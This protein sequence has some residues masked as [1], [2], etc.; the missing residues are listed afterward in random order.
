MFQVAILKLDLR[1]HRFSDFKK[2][3][4]N[5]VLWFLVYSLVDRFCLL[6]LT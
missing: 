6:Y 3:Y 1:C 4:V 2:I 5:G